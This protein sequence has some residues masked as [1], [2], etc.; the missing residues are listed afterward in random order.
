MVRALGLTSNNTYT[1]TKSFGADE[2][3]VVDGCLFAP[4][5]VSGAD[6]PRVGGLRA[7]S[8]ITAISEKGLYRLTLR[9][10]KPQARVFQDWVTGEVLPSIRKTGSYALADHGRTEMPIPAEFMAVIREAMQAQALLGERVAAANPACFGST[11]K[12]PGAGRK[13]P[14]WEDMRIRR[15]VYVIEPFIV[16]SAIITPPRGTQ[17]RRNTRHRPCPADRIGCSLGPQPRGLPRRPRPAARLSDTL[18]PPTPPPPPAA[19]D[20]T[21]QDH[22]KDAPKGFL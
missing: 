20:Q 14:F 21:D 16:I 13:R 9:S 22:F 17:A 6:A 19:P 3:R 15:Q 1:H 7:N 10:D 18:G 5:S 12:G 2:K 4:Q 8:P 11:D